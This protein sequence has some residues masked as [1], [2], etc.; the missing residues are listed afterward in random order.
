MESSSCRMWLQREACPTKQLFLASPLAW[1]FP[2]RA[3]LHPREE[4]RDKLEEAFPLAFC[5]GTALPREAEGGI[6]SSCKLAGMT[7]VIPGRKSRFHVSSH[8]TTSSAVGTRG[9][10]RVSRWLSSA[11]P[12]RWIASCALHIGVST[13]KRHFL[14]LH[15]RNFPCTDI[16]GALL[17]YL[18]GASGLSPC[19]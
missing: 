9:C 7:L 19:P 17:P 8:P 12:G 18:S 11:T 5:L 16:A 14:G 6:Q 1:P 4:A 10:Y 13:S 3:C 15:G 2:G